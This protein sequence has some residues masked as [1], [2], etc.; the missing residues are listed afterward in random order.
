MLIIDVTWLI[1]HITRV[2]LRAR[3]WPECNRTV[4]QGKLRADKQ[5]SCT[6]GALQQRSLRSP[7]LNS[8]TRCLSLTFF[9]LLCQYRCRPAVMQSCATTMVSVSCSF[10]TSWT[11]GIRKDSATW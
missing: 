7:S 9:S 6:L 1:S 11:T 2:R 3:C 10:C 8:S 4:S 5:N